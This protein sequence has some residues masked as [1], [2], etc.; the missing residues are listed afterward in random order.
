MSTL[1]KRAVLLNT[2]YNL[3]STFS[4]LFL[5]VYLYAYTG[6]LVIMCIY[7]I[8]RI[9]LF[10]MFFIL[11]SKIVRKHNFSLTFTI[12]LIFIASSL[13]YALFGGPLFE[14]NPYY[15]LF[16]AVLTG[17]GEGFFWFSSNTLNVV[18]STLESRAKFLSMSGAFQAI[19]ALCAPFIANFIIEN[20]ATD[21]SAYRI[22]LTIVLCLYIVVIIISRFIDINGGAKDYKLI[23]SFSF[24]D[25]MWNDH[26]LAVVLYGLRNS[27]TLALTGLLVFNAAGD[28]GVYS[29][30]QSFF[31]VITI[32]SFFLISKGLDRKRIK[33]TFKIGVFLAISS[34]VVL[35][36][37]PNIYGA[38][39]FGISNALC[40][41]FYDNSYN[42]LSAN[43]ISNYRSDMAGRVVVRE[44][45]LSI[46]RCIGMGII[47]L[48]YYV[49]PEW[50]YLK[51]S[52]I[53]LSI[54][55]IFVY[56]I[57]IK[58]KEKN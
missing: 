58:Y 21:M 37:I 16:A 35:V 24:N 30:L 45:W 11:G 12:G 48:F 7:T 5:N 32:V 40:S 2:I 53:L 14:I 50:L 56:R 46:S 17:I 25:K 23:E 49:L 15:V 55:S 41:V 52:V 31:A 36:M 54:T 10:P 27:L 13:L 26:N 1:E 22:I 34:T 29:K 57:L 28:G 19:A 33:N 51:A 47:V 42:F 44:T 4:I 6:S 20:S 3:S 39:F 38:I 8:V 9:G 43:I 18:V